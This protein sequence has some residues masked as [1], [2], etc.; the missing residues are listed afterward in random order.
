[1]RLITQLVIGIE[2]ISNYDK[3]LISSY[4]TVAKK[5]VLKCESL[6]SFFIFCGV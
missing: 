6:L 5:K 1:M 4:V 2:L 3:K